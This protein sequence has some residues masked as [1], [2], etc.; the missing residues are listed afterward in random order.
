MS[1]W[2]GLK[3]TLAFL[4]ENERWWYWTLLRVLLVLVFCIV[5]WTGVL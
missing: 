2:Q 4:W 5:L 3:E 1:Y